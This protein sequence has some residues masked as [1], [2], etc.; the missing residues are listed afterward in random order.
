MLRLLNPVQSLPAEVH[1]AEK[2]FNA[3][4]SQVIH[5]FLD[6]RGKGMANC[7]PVVIGGK[8]PS[9]SQCI[10]TERN[11]KAFRVSCQTSKA[12]LSVLNFCV[13][14]VCF[15]TT[16]CLQHVLQHLWST[17]KT[18]PLLS[19][20][21]PINNADSQE[22]D[23]DSLENAGILNHAG[24]CV[25]RAGDDVIKMPPVVE[26][27]FKE[28][29]Q[30]MV[31]VEKVVLNNVLEGIG[32]DV[33]NECGIHRFEIQ[34]QFLGVFQ[35][36]HDKATII[37]R[38]GITQ[39]KKETIQECF[40]QLA[41]DTQLRQAWMR[42]LRIEEGCKLCDQA[43]AV[44]ILKSVVF[45]FLKSKQMAICR[46]MYVAPDKKSI[47]LR[48]SL[49]SGK[50]VNKKAAGQKR[51]MSV[52]KNIL[53]AKMR[54]NL[55]DP[56]N[57]GDALVELGEMENIEEFVAQLS[58]KEITR[59]LKSMGKPSYSGKGKAVLIPKFVAV[60]KSGIMTII[61]PEEVTLLAMLC[62]MSLKGKSII[63]MID[64]KI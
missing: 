48:Q 23:D 43:A 50:K 14:D 49:Q 18:K 34:E 6:F 13:L 59:L 32:E 37:L 39:K 58:G 41:R 21:H 54:N 57:L 60:I 20:S 38:D 36:L 62:F 24:W 27:R 3:S 2:L 55:H 63:A 40:T 1:I 56:K 10:T 7:F 31:K 9:S 12:W 17:A 51:K 44:I 47:A 25:K 53:I 64:D 29:S 26:L 61:H 22:S 42:A 33:A 28:G 16:S 30:Q 52:D 5:D 19:I 15:E 8:G 35:M 11:F 4:A 46:R 45:Y